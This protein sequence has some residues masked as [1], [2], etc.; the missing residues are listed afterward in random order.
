MRGG[1][2]TMVILVVSDIHLGYSHSN[3]DEFNSFLQETIGRSDVKA[4]VILGDLIDMWRRDISGLFLENYQVVE[5]I[6]AL[7]RKIPVYCVVGN[8]DYHLLN[9]VDHK[10]PL[11]FKN[12][13]T[14]PGHKVTYIFRHGYEFDSEQWLPLV[15]LLCDN[16]SDQVGQVIDEIWTRLNSSGQTLEPLKNLLKLLDLS[17]EKYLQH[18][19]LPPKDRLAASIGDVEKKAAESVKHGQLLVFGH[20]HRPFVSPTQNLVNTGCWVNDEETFNIYAELDGKN[21]RLIQYGK[22]DVTQAMIRKV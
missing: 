10:Y 21:I 7:K 15:K 16:V 19:L 6:L 2:R 22:G 5:S 14:L 3:V 11:E 8:H 18:L 20:T 12:E 9:L 1:G 13:L 17:Q 4:L